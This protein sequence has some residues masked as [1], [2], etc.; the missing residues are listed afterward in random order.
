MIELG[1]W[2]PKKLSLI[3]ICLRENADF[4]SNRV[5]YS[6]LQNWYVGYLD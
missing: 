5:H 2:E 6:H 4:E 3:T 1:L